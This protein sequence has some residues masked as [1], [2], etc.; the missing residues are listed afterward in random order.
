MQKKT[1]NR[2]INGL[3]AILLVVGLVLVFINLIRNQLVKMMAHRQMDVT[4]AQIKKNQHKK[5]SFDFDKVDSLDTKQIVNAA[6]KGDVIVLG[7]VAIPSVKMGL[8]SHER[9]LRG[10]N[11]SRWRHNET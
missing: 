2:L 10:H 1:R 9:R 7:K 11:G 5:A 6:I 4:A 3:L 8:A